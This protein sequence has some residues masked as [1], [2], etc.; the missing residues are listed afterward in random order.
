MALATVPSTFT[1]ALPPTVPSGPRAVTG[2]LGLAAR[3]S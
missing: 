3:M 2:G 1:D